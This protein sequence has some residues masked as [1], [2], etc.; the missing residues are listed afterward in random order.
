MTFQAFETFVSVIC[1]FFVIREIRAVKLQL[2][3]LADELRALREH[4]EKVHEI[5]LNSRLAEIQ[6]MK[7]SP[8]RNLRRV[9]NE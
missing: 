1:A 9:P 5:D 3:F 2:N 8:V 4:D 7:F 6:R